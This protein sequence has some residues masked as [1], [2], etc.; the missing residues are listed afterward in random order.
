MSLTASELSHLAVGRITDPTWEILRLL[1]PLD[2]TALS[3]ASTSERLVDEVVARAGAGAAGWAVENSQ[4]LLTELADEPFINRERLPQSEVGF[5]EA[6]ALWVVLRLTGVRAIPDL[7]SAEL[8]KAIRERIPDDISVDQALACLRKAH[9]HF[10]QALFRFVETMLPAPGQAT[11]MRLVSTELFAGMETLAATVTEAFAAERSRWFAG[12]AGERA[13]LVNAILK[14]EPVDPAKAMRRLGYELTLH[15]VALVLWQDELT[16]DG[17][18]ELEATALRVLDR[19]G[20]SSTLLLPAGSGRLWAWGGRA[21]SRPVALRKVAD[22]P[23][24]PAGVHVASGLPG[25]GV[26]GFQ[27]SHAQAITA[28]R[29]GRV[30]EPKPDRLYDYGEMELAIL[31]GGEVAGAAEFVR[32]ELGPLA[33]CDK[34]MVAV[35]ETVRCLLDNERSVAAT[36][37]LMHIAKN[38]VVYRA[39]KAEQLL[40]RS[41]REDRLRLHLA[42]HLAD[43][44][45]PVLL[46]ERRGTTSDDAVLPAPRRA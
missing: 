2:D 16:P 3:L 38:T 9:A 8:T 5:T 41:L 44:L 20:C 10:S 27:R 45:G 23:A 15:H 19:L 37:E 34:S 42:L 18:R 29:V 24:F 40:G 35:R 13:T 22:L 25:D 28:E 30:A 21:S 31:L 36:A 11:A 46:S 1:R 12:S 33:S 14:G 39:K 26:A 7:L 6:V 4:L 17:G 43:Q 32:R